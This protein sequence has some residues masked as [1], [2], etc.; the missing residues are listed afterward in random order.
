MRLGVAHQLTSK[1]TSYV[2]V[3]ERNPTVV[4]Q[5]YMGPVVVQ[6]IQQPF[7]SS[8]FAAP[9]LKKSS[10]APTRIAG[11]VPGFAASRGPNPAADMISSAAGRKRSSAP[12]A[13]FAMKE[14]SRRADVDEEE[15][16]FA[17]VLRL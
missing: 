11:G 10:A 15:E 13:A 6:Q 1:Y 3:Q 9:K 17:P 2:A 16:E 7:S 5:L 12:S 8:Q 4:Y 14:N